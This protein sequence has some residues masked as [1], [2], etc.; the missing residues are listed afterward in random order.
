MM[1][2][3]SNIR[4]IPVQTSWGRFVLAADHVGLVALGWPGRS[5]EFPGRL[6]A[7]AILEEAPSPVLLKAA[8]EL[9]EYI[10]LRRME[11]SV[12]L[13]PAGTRFQK[14][15]WKELGRIPFGKTITYGR[16]A[17]R[18]RNPAASRAV[19]NAAGANPLPVFIPCHRLVA[20]GGK[21]GGFSAGIRW[22]NK[23]LRH[24]KIIT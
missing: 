20:A 24:E 9:N 5:R 12:P 23:L 7:D 14:R 11:F 15:V 13:N 8:K 10:N 22:K 21:P 18:I 17:G 19:G 4:F 16:L 3:I 1:K 6:E 2:V